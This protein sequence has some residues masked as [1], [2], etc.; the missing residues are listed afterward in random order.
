MHVEERP[1]KKDRHQKLPPY[2]RPGV[3]G[4]TLEPEFEEDEPYDDSDEFIVRGGRITQ[5]ISR[6]RRKFRDEN[7]DE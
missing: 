7:S 1:M 5:K 3:R 2:L 4:R 6:H